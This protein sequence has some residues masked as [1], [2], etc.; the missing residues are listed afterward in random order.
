ME[1]TN[2]Q[3]RAFAAVSK[4]MEDP[5]GVF[6]LFGFAGTG[7]TTL[8]KRVA[9]DLARTPVFAAYTGKAAGVLTSKGCP[10][11]TTIHKL[12]YAPKDRSKK[13]LRELEAEKIALDESSPDFTTEL[14]RLTREIAEETKRLK[15]PLFDLRSESSL[16]LADLLIL[17]ETSMV[18]E[19]I[20]A[21]LESFGT[22]ILALGDPAQLQ[23]VKAK[24]AYTSARPDYLLTEI[25]RQAEG[26]PI[27]ELARIAREGLAPTVGSYGDGSARVIR[28]EDLNATMAMDADQILVGRNR[29]R[30]ANNVRMRELLGYSGGPVPGDRVVCLRNNHENGLLNGSTWIVIEANDLDDSWGLSIKEEGGDRELTVTAHKQPFDD[31]EIPWW[32]AKD[33][34]SFDYAYAMT[35]HKAQGS[36]WDK[37]LVFDESHVFRNERSN[38]LYTAVTRAAKELTI[39]V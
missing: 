29:T 32:E 28:R 11:A 18:S 1:W 39:V 8:A 6:R 33:H 3:E 23:P 14:T 36:Q 37:V 25:V 7:K 34:D 31:E 24:A 4:W 21:D 9:E 15:S 13:R 38:W 26:S 27:L 16:D 12:I 22:P 17:D 20:A 30:R 35:V 5:H 10:G 2:D 19:E